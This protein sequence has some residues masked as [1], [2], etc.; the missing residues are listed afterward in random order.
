MTILENI[1]FTSSAVLNR[2]LRQA[3]SAALIGQR[4]PKVV[5]RF[6]LFIIYEDELFIHLFI[7]SLFFCEL[8]VLFIFTS[9]WLFLILTQGYVFFF[10]FIFRERG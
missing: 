3:V 7:G 5:L 9:I 4:D 2:P 8:F 6:I 1:F 10:I